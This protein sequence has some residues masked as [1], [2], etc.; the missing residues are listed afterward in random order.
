MRKRSYLIG[1][2]ARPTPAL[3]WLYVIVPIALVMVLYSID[4]ASYLAANPNGK[5]VPSFFMMVE[6]IWELAF[7][8]D[9]RTHTYLLWADTAA[10]LY[11][12]VTGL[13]L[14]AA[15]GLLLGLNIALF[16]ALR[17]ILL[18][19]GCAFVCPDDGAAAHPADRRGYR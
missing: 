8:Q 16:P 14:A 7:T 17:Y 9:P 18:P 2:N 1:I 13:A 3:A 6:R 19:G 12:F 4:S 5:I 11:R 10:S 15:V